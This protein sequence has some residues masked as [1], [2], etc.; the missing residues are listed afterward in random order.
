M[1]PMCAAPGLARGAEGHRL[2]AHI[3]AMKISAY[4]GVNPGEVEFDPI[5][6]TVSFT[7]KARPEFRPRVPEPGARGDRLSW[8]KVEA[9]IP[10]GSVFEVQGDTDQTEGRGG[11]Y[12]AGYFSTH[13]AAW[14]A[15]SGL[16]VQGCPGHVR[17]APMPEKVWDSVKEWH[18]NR[19]NSKSK[20]R[21]AAPTEL[22]AVFKLV[23]G[24]TDTLGLASPEYAAYL[25][26]KAKF[27]P[28][29]AM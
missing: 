22:G 27:E 5:T 15:S 12:T 17:I 25:V 10:D 28:E 9:E 8:F 4:A 2:A 14:N 29:A 20:V 16:G 6:R 7:S 24:D 21:A 1:N 26:L 11:R 19:V 3:V 23:Q 13:E 18:S